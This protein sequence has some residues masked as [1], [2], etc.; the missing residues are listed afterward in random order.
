M[1]TKKPEQPARGHFIRH[2]LL[3]LLVIV[4][5]GLL[6]GCGGT[7]EKKNYQPAGS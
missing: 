3:G 5:T 2:L 4:A 7:Q 1:E 6:F